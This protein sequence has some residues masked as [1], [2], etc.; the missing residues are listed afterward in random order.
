M[1]LWRFHGNSDLFCFLFDVIG[2]VLWASHG[3]YFFFPGA[4]LRDF[5]V[6]ISLFCFRSF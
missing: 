6:G 2:D 5:F 3:L 4:L 1:F